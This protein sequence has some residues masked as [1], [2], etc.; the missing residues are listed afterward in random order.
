MQIKRLLRA[1]NWTYMCADGLEELIRKR[2]L[3]IKKLQEIEE[4]IKNFA[5]QGYDKYHDQYEK[6]KGKIKNKLS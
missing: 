1:I 4:K 5:T 6:T 2:D 3:Q